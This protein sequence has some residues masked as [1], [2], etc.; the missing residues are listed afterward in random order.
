MRLLF[1]TGNRGKLGELR[2]L[3]GGALEVVSPS[4]LG[5]SLELEED[6]PTFEA[7]AQ[8]KARAWAKASGLW[9]LADDSGLC[10]DALGGR[11]GVHSARYAPD[12]ASRILRLLEELSGVP[13]E[14]RS[15]RF[16]CALCLARPEGEAV[17]ETGEL[18]GRILPVP[19]GAGGFGYDPVFF[20]PAAGKTLAQL[21][22][23]EKSAISHR[24]EAFRKMK[25]RL[26][27]D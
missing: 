17:V 14:K 12:D 23:Q 19:R 25:P 18:E 11:P 2:E 22:R 15:A 6:Q 24:G 8:K 10:V 4:E 26:L 21:S 5:L 7:N 1:A 9:A 27:L 3:L 16:R 13:E 20:V